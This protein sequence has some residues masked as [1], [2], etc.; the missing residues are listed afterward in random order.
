MAPKSAKPAK[1]AQP[2]QS[3]ELVE[4]PGARF[5]VASENLPI[6]VTYALDGSMT[7][8]LKKPVTLYCF[9][10]LSG[11]LRTAGHYLTKLELDCRQGNNRVVAWVCQTKGGGPTDLKPDDGYKDNTY[12]FQ[13]TKNWPV[14]EVIA[15]SIQVDGSS[16]FK[17]LSLKMSLQRSETRWKKLL[18]RFVPAPAD[19]TSTA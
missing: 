2:V 10:D 17:L 7:V 19:K 15:V 8:R 14:D 1:P 16:E 4:I 3:K 12:T 11:H 9:F 6:E 13:F 18:Q 5:Q